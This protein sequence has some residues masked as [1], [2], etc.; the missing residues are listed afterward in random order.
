MCN[1]LSVNG[2]TCL[3]EWIIISYLLAATKGQYY[4]ARFFDLILEEFY[5]ILH[6]FVHNPR[7]FQ[8]LHIVS[9]VIFS[10]QKM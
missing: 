4:V 3:M 2:Y 9:K 5:I 10:M 1:N 6:D 7:T 8:V